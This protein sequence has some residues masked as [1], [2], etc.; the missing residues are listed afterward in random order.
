MLHVHVHAMQDL[1][2]A[3]AEQGSPEV[4]DILLSQNLFKKDKDE[5]AE[6]VDTAL[7]ASA[8]LGKPDIVDV[9]IKKFPEEVKAHCKAGVFRAYK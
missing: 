9:L 8:E 5:L 3:A 1:I 6:A 7:K 2:K 4:M